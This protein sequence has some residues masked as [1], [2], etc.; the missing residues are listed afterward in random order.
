MSVTAMIHDTA[1]LFII[2][3][4]SMPYFAFRLG[5]LTGA[6]AAKLAG[7]ITVY[8]RIANFVLIISLLTGLMRV[9]WTFSGWVLMV[10]AIFL[11]IAALLGISMKAAKNIGTE[12]AAERDI[13]GS[14]AKFQRVSML[15]AAAIIVMVLVKIV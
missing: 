9:G 7:K 13:A 3:C 11:A 6:D 1:A 4:L 10:L 14:V 15:L 2:T 12:A 5:K 8:L